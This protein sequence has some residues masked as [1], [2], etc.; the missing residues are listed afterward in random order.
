M[1]QKAIKNQFKWEKYKGNVVEWV[2][3]QILNDEVI[4]Q[5]EYRLLTYIFRLK[6][7]T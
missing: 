5:I 3:N 6:N 7:M 1:A 2:E 4:S